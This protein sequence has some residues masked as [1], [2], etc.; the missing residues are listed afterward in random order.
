MVQSAWVSQLGS[1]WTVKSDARQ[2]ITAYDTQAHAIDAARALLSAIGGGG[3]I[4][5]DQS[6]RVTQ[7]EDIA[8][9]G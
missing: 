1:L 2:V 3:L 4:V 7:R 8:P 9:P 5:K 6:G